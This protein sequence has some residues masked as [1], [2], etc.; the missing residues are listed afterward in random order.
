VTQSSADDVHQR[1]LLARLD[2]QEARRRILIHHR[3]YLVHL[4]QSH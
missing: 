2:L 1:A 4:G 3:A